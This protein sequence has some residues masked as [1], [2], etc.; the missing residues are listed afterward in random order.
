MALRKLSVVAALGLAAR[1]MVFRI[2]PDPTDL[3]CWLDMSSLADKRQSLHGCSFRLGPQY[4][5]ERFP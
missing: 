3:K 2:P 5:T 4:R 1:N